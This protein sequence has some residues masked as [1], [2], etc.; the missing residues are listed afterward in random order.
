[1]VYSSGLVPNI[2]YNTLVFMRSAQTAALG[3]LFVPI[4][5]IAYLTLPLRLRSDGAAMY[6]MFRN[7]FG[8]VGISLST[9]MVTE[10]TQANQAQLSKFM[11]PLQ[12]GYSNLVQQSEAAL[13]TLGRAPSA[14][15]D[16]AVSHVYQTYLKQ[17]AVLA[18]GN[19]FLYAS[20]LAF[21]IAPLCLLISSKKASGRRWWCALKRSVGLTVAG[22]ASLAVVALAGCVGPNFVPPIP[23]TADSRTFLDTGK[24]AVAPVSILGGSTNAPSQVEW[25]QVFRDPILSRLESRVADKN[26]DVRTATLRIAQS[27]AQVA[28][29][30]SAA[31]P[32]VNGT[33]SDY[34]QQF[35]QNGLFSLVPIQSLV[36]TQNASQASRN[37]QR[38]QQL[39]YRLRCLLG[40][41]LVGP[42]RPA[43]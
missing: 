11:T 3:F 41:R 25:W 5:Q 17:A 7:V 21:L 9:A 22:A 34:R 28:S 16:Q 19:V 20:V 12:G 32:T 26:L 27:R 23:A 2:D 40:D 4:S 13:R 42:R 29:T 31:L 8:S 18:Y 24:A 38:L 10:R 43:D 1:M 14:V 36:P 30:A 6:S 35:S 15:H 33:F 37:R 39:L